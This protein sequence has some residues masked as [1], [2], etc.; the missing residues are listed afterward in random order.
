MKIKGISR[1]LIETMV[2]RGNQLG[3]GRQVGTIG[4]INEAGVIDCYNQIID[5]GV[6]GLPH[7]HMLQE[8]SHRDKASLI[9]MINS[10][11][12]NAVYIRTDP[13]QTGI[14]VSTS[15]INIFNLPVINI[16]VKHGQVAGI[17]I[18]YPEEK[19]FRLATRSENAQLDS[20]AAKDMEAEKKA[21]EKV[22]RLRLEFLNISEELPIID[23]NVSQNCQ[24][25]KK[26]WVIDRQEPVSVETGFA[27]ELVKK[28]LEVEPGR[29]VAAFGRIDENGHI[30]RCS[31][32]V[33]GGMGYIPSRLLASSYKD[34][35]GLSLR[36][37]YSEKMP[38]NTAIVHTHPGGSGVMHMSDAM[39]GPGMWGRPIVAVGHDEK[40]DI[41]G[42]MAIKTQDRLFELADENEYLE[43]QFFKVQKPEEEVKLRKRRYK[44]AQEFTDLCDQL[45]LKTTEEETEEKLA[46]SN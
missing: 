15:A 11:P 37:F 18:L 31:G 16:G 33:V 9:E 7:R 2:R 29:E 25:A 24:R 44:I 20:L 39:A 14:I 28:S 21:L 12:D 45:K 27:E 4:F 10:L 34:I 23:D 5:G 35:T 42:V 6:S 26:P 32:I 8:I 13:G 36:E 3:Q 41:K 19:H 1:D 46:V 17:G 40:G 30:T 43:Q 38:L 22:T